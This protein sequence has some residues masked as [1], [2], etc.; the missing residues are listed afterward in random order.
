M[1]DFN[2]TRKLL[3]TT[4]LKFILYYRYQSI[5]IMRYVAF[6][7]DYD[8]TL[9]KNGQVDQTTLAALKRLQESGRKLIL[10]TGRQLEDLFQAFPEVNSCDCVVAENG[11]V[12]YFPETREER[13]L[14]DRP[15]EAFIQALQLQ[16]V[17]PLS[18][19]KVI[20]AT[21]EPHETTVLEAIRDLGLELQVIFNK[22]AVMVLPPSVNKATGLSA[23]LTQMGLS[24]HNTV[25]VGDAEN[26]HAFLDLCEVSVAVANALPAV[27][28]RTDWVTQGSRGEGV[29]QLIENLIASDL[30]ELAPALKRHDIL[31]GTKEDGT[32][33]QLQPYGS[34]ILVA[35]TS[36][37]GKSTLATGVLERLAE[38]SYQFCIIDPEGDYENFDGAVVLGNSHQAPSVT[39]VLDLLSQSHQNLVVNLLGV[40]LEERPSF[41]VGLLPSLLEMRARTGRPHWLV[42][43]E[44]HHML[45]AS[46][47]TASLTLPQAL[48][49]MMLITV[50]PDHV[51]V[52]A[53]SLIDT[54]IAVGQSP[55]QTIAAFCEKLEYERPSHL[56]QKLE[57][58]KV[59]AWFYRDQVEPFSFQIKPPQ[60]ERQRHMRNY[61][62]G[63]L[64]EDKS[65]YFRGAE[66]KLNLRAENL[67]SFTRLAEGIDEDTWMHH[68]QRQ[69]YSNWFREA[70][71]DEKL[72][73]EAAQVETT[74]GLSAT[75][76]R[77]RIKTAI[78]RR[79]T[80]SA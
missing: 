73:E 34:S 55:D 63:Q 68:L 19:G 42:I 58:G 15:P 59:L 80:L 48:D 54:I 4:T 67:I 6:A 60:M 7:T 44:A 5:K 70:I 3:K 12:L 77:N 62:E 72:A 47:H 37:G 13:R 74:L 41:L 76:S 71:K 9:A 39:E 50:H 24:P 17:S 65:F 66:A 14:G 8:G 56:P 36:G 61:A 78:E 40:K 28:E 35:G 10:V 22:G 1:S 64:G 32:E 57:P 29:T 52:P 43:D 30:A 21:W 33:V 75:E 20:V 46:L 26:D 25:A 2:G 11:A 18:V 16:N 69:D 45:P 23:A 31:L 51:A 27:K 49:S 79:Y 53:L 38:K